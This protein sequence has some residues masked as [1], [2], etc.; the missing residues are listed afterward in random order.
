MIRGI[1]KLPYVF[2]CVLP[3]TTDDL[4]KNILPIIFLSL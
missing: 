3:L 1:I 2:L 4:W